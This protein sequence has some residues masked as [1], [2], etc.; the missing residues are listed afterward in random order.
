MGTGRV[1]IVRVYAYV[2]VLFFCRTRENRKGETYAFVFFS[3]LD[4]A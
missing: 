4:E 1:G 3:D 2:G